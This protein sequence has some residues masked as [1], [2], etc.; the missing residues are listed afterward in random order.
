[1]VTGDPIWCGQ[2]F[3]PWEIGHYLIRK[4]NYM[5][6]QIPTDL[7][8]ILYPNKPPHADGSLLL[9]SRRTSL[10]KILVF[11]NRSIVKPSLGTKLC[12]VSRALEACVA[13]RE[14]GDGPS[15]LEWS[16]AVQ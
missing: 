14:V 6:T 8:R 12:L 10:K 3:V 7:V 2:G 4:S 15:S 11:L 16:L 5:F 1:M 13:C 9:A